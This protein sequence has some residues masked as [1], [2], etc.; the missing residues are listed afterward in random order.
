VILFAAACAWLV[1]AVG[2]VSGLPVW[3]VAPA[4]TAAAA[5][6][7]AINRQH[8]LLQAGSGVL[9]VAFALLVLRPA[10][11]AAQSSIVAGGNGS[12]ERLLLVADSTPDPHPSYLALNATVRAVARDGA[13]QPASGRVRLLLPPGASVGSGDEL[14]VFGPIEPAS[15][16]TSAG[17]GAWLARQGIV[18]TVAFPRVVQVVPGSSPALARAWNRLRLDLTGGLQRALPQNEALLAAALLFGGRHALPAALASDLQDSGLSHIASVSSFKLVLLFAV[19]TALSTPLIGRRRGAV[20]GCALALLYGLL[21]GGGA[22]A[23]R[24]EVLVAFSALALVTGRPSGRVRSLVLAAALLSVFNVGLLSDPGF[25]LSFAAAA[26]ETLLAPW[27]IGLFRGRRLDDEHRGPLTFAMIETLA[28]GMSIVLAATPVSAAVFGSVPAYGLA[29]NAIVLP[30]VPLAT[31]LAFLAGASG[32]FL[33][34]LS[35]LLAAPLWLLLRCC[36]GVAHL[37]AAAPGAT[38]S[39]PGSG[40]AL[41]FGWYGALLAAALGWRIARSGRRATSK[42]ARSVWRPL[43]RTRPQPAGR[44]AGRLGAV[45]LAAAA[46]ALL[47]TTVSRGGAPSATSV[48]WLSGSR[49]ALYVQ[50]R[51]G[52]RAIVY[53]GAAPERLVSSAQSTL[54][55]SASAA[56]L[57]ELHTPVDDQ[58]RAT[59][60]AE[61]RAVH[62][63]EVIFPTAGM[64]Q[65]TQR[66]NGVT[67]QPVSHAARLPLGGDDALDL[68]STG[69][70]AVLRLTVA[71][72]VVVVP[73]G[74]DTAATLQQWDDPARAD[75]VALLQPAAFDDRSTLVSLQPQLVVGQLRTGEALSLAQI[76]GPASAVDLARARD[77]RL[78]PRGRHVALSFRPR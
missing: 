72:L 48:T 12:A 68:L 25:Q 58:D 22:S 54:G 34:P 53:G 32:A 36:E 78:A 56:V 33:A 15:A 17:Y 43:Y 11:P 30:F 13:W 6:A 42:R 73:A 51:N 69:Q 75:V 44:V 70:G 28:I 38:V 52:A 14:E 57:I 21:S 50:G 3:F 46:P 55:A 1:F 10:R 40:K 47:V 67:L 37:A 35:S 4:A 2:H 76:A 16:S 18:A 8:R 63:A 45:V 29:A 41:A 23:L 59:F 7:P 27:L 65:T 60:A 24:G 61:A 74:T 5:I 62:A 64:D 39:L 49:P 66:V 9:V 77:V 20:A 26:G 71:G 31:G 19:V